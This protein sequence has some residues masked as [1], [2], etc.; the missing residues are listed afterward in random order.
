MIY[1]KKE[2]E[3]NNMEVDFDIDQ[4]AKQTNLFLEDHRDDDDNDR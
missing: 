2:Y 3:D 1:T 4:V